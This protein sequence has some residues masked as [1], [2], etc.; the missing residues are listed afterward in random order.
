MDEESDDDIWIS[1]DTFRVNPSES[2]ACDPKYISILN[3]LKKPPVLEEEKEPYDLVNNAKFVGHLPVERVSD[4]DLLERVKE[5]VPKGTVDNTSGVLRCGKIGKKKETRNVC[6]V[7]KMNLLLWEKIWLRCERENLIIGLPNL[8]WRCEEKQIVS[9]I[10]E[11]P[12]IK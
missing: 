1:Q 7:L 4:I 8:S 11:I 12:F 6:P 2:L 9:L 3:D 10:M 5:R